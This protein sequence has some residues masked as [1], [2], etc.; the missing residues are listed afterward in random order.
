MASF[1]KSPPRKDPKFLDRIRALPCVVCAQPARSEASHIKTRG[2]G[3][4][5]DWFNVTPKCAVHH[6]EWEDSAPRDFCKRYPHFNEY[7]HRL[8]WY[9]T[10]FGKLTHPELQKGNI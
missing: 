8:G 5:D 3:G 6:R 9:F 2:S 10:D 1:P 7:L 4:G